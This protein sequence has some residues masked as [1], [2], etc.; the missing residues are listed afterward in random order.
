[1][2]P[3]P[4]RETRTETQY[5]LA[6]NLGLRGPA[7]T[8]QGAEAKL[9]ERLADPT[10]QPNGPLRIQTRTVTYGPWQDVPV[11]TKGDSA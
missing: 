6:D 8:L 7:Y 4:A 9:R 10:S 5:R 3:D 1:M 11:E 2:S